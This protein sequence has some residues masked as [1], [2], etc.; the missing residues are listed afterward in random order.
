[1][2]TPPH[3]THPAQPQP[4]PPAPPHRTEPPIVAGVAPHEEGLTLG[5]RPKDPRDPQSAK[6]EAHAAPPHW[7]AP[8][9][10]AAKPHEE[11]SPPKAALEPLID[12]RPADEKP[13]F[14]P[15]ALAGGG[16]FVTP[17][18]QKQVQGVAPP[19]KRS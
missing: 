16:A 3:P 9:K 19:T 15:H 1:M 6:F 8:N 10:D 7:N 5:A 12:Q 11:W 17:G 14:D 2:A 4:K 18:A 13:T